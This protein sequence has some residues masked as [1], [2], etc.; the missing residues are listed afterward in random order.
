LHSTD[1]NFDK[2]HY[3][4]GGAVA[5]PCVNSHWLSQWEPSFLTPHRI[6][7]P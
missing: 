4:A 1:K 7:V 6:D 3:I 5:Q 2:L